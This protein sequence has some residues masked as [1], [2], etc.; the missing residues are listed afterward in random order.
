MKLFQPDTRQ[1]RTLGAA[2]AI[3]FA[4]AVLLTAFFQTQVVSGEEYAVRS[5][6]N[7]L[8]PIP[9]SAPRGTIVDRNGEIVATS[10][11]GYTVHLLPAE[12]GIIRRTLQDLAPFLGLSRA[13]VEELVEEQQARPN[14]L[15]EI[16]DDAT[17]S[18]VA[19]I[20]ERRTSFP[21]LMIVER[22]KR[23]YPAG[24][25]IAHMIGYV[26]EITKE[27]LEFPRYQQAGYQQ[28]RWVGKAGIEKQYELR[29]GGQ[30]G[31]RFVEVDAMGRVVDP[32]STVGAVAPTPGEDLKLTLDLELQK[33]VAEIFPDTMKGA[34]VAM[35]P[36]TGEVLALYS[37]PSYDPN[38]FVGGISTSLWNALRGDSLNPLLD[39]TISAL[40]PPASTW[41]LA[42]AA[43]GVK[44]GIV[45]ADTRMPAPCTGGMYYAG[46]Y[47]RCWYKAGHGYLDLA[48]A[49]EKSCNVYFY[50]LGIR[51][52]LLELTKQGTR[53]GFN[54]ETGIDLPNER[55]PIF[56]TGKEWYKERFGNEPT[57]SEVMSLSIGQG[58]NSQSVLRMAHFYSAIA[59]NGS[60]PEPHLVE[61]EG[62]GEGPGAIDLGLSSEQLQQLWAGLYKVTAPGGTGVL[63]SLENWKLYGK[64][65]T[66][67]NPQG[68]DHGWFVGFAGPPG[69]HPE[70]VVAAIVE[71]GEHGDDVAPIAAKVVNFYLNRKHGLPVDPQPTLIERWESGRTPW[72]QYDQYPAPTTPAP[73]APAPKQTASR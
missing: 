22:P 39:R 6:R 23:F 43:I 37:N 54:T 36:S 57:P 34:V 11:T 62:A 73:R 13:Q 12:P 33:Y 14:D 15:L 26:S 64:T 40:Y 65:G 7:R 18:Q 38:D 48:S 60:A 56:P 58:P 51:L 1:R 4:I 19:A 59:G 50:Q 21:N 69:G 28:G 32:R 46:R 61:R 68:K 72:S 71:H 24:P 53:F 52:G 17:Y 2:F 10:V 20:E 42:T 3:T 5:E 25:A 41:K 8:R 45:T 9:I 30:E 70:I 27:E 49:I 67:Q 35:V 29:L 55:T 31:A 16:T 63:S 47:F 66:A 44:K